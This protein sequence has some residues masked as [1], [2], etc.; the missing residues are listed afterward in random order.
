MNR[1][2]FLL[3]NGLD[4]LGG[5][6]KSTSTIGN[7]LIKNGYEVSIW[8]P[9]YKKNLTSFPD[10]NTIIYN[11]K[12]NKIIHLL[13]RVFNLYKT[14]K[15]FRPDIIHAQDAQCAILAVFLKKNR[16]IDKKIKIFYTDRKFLSSYKEKSRNLFIKYQDYFSKII[17]TTDT[18]AKNWKNYTNIMNIETINNVLDS[19][20]YSFDD[21]KRKNSRVE[22]GIENKINVSFCARFEKYKRWDTVYEI[23]KQLSTDDRF[24]F[25]FALVTLDVNEKNFV[26]YVNELK[27]MLGKK[28]FIYVNI[29]NKEDMKLFYY[30]SDFFIM[31]S[32]NE[33]FGRTILEA[34]SKKC[35]SLG[36]N[37]GG[38]PDVIKND[39]Y[40]FE[41]NDFINVSEKIKLIVND[42]NKFNQIKESQYRFFID[43]YS[44]ERFE[45]KTLEI[46]EVKE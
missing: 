17:C 35:I 4:I 26:S 19:D 11:K 33:S 46:Y 42:N 8:C 21:C 3:D 40:L 29:K 38:V 30:K 15:H 43:E 44:L 32:E 27:K 37:S 14:I 12:N 18:N 16:L 9:R 25:S 34:M 45:K 10:D 39:E 1:I 36:T 6:P 7:I 31:T 22:I 2:L 41:V 24:V 13:S 23:C 20:W 5:S 28:A